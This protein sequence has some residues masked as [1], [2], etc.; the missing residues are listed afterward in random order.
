MSYKPW[1][2]GGF[3]FKMSSFDDVKS[4]WDNQQTKI[5]TLQKAIDVL[6]E[7]N[8]FSESMRCYCMPDI[9]KSC[10]PCRAREAKQKVKEIL[11]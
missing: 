7:A 8:E 9:P 2:Y 11:G 5:E 4:D 6:M 10:I 1:W 3:D